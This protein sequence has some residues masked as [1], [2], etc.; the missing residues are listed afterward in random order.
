MGSIFVF[1]I[2]SLAGGIYSA[3]LYATTAYGPNNDLNYVQADGNRSRWADGAYQLA[4]VAIT[5]VIALLMGGLMGGIMKIF[6]SSME[7]EDYF[8][9]DAFI[10]KDSKKE[11]QQTKII[12]V[13]V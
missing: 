3:I 7:R 11:L 1:L 8:S 10:K 6:N 5:I 2:P 13:N 9:D 12:K 4:G